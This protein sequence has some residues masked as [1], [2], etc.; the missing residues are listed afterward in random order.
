MPDS[1]EHEFVVI[2]ENSAS[3]FGCHLNIGKWMLINLIQGVTDVTL[4]NVWIQIKLGYIQALEE[5]TTC[6]DDGQQTGK[7]DQAYYPE[8]PSFCCEFSSAPTHIHK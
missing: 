6:D 5:D 7:T 3:R 1:F 4:M 8:K 2:T